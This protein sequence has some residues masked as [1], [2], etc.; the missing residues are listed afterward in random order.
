MQV[1]SSPS[2]LFKAGRYSELAMLGDSGHQ[3]DHQAE[4]WAD[5]WEMHAARAMIGMPE[6][7][8][9]PLGRFDDA[10]ARFFQAA[11][12]WIAGDAQ[13]ARALC[14]RLDS[15]AAA[16]LA[17]LLARD[18]LDILC[19]LPAN[20]HGPHVHLAGA[21]ADP[22]FRIANISHH[23]DDL[24]LRP[25][26]SIWNYADRE[27]PP[28]L[29]LCEMVEWH[30]IPTDFQELPCPLIGV[31]S[32]FDLHIQGIQP[33]LNAFDLVVVNDHTEYAGLRGCITP[34]MAVFPLLFGCPA[35]LP[36]PA[37]GPRDIDLFM[38]GTLFATYHPDKAALLHAAL[39][40]PDL[41]VVLVNGHMP[42]AAY[43]D[44]LARSKLTASYY[45]RPG[46]MVTRGIEAACMGCVL[47]L[48]E[49]SVLDL[50]A[51]AR[52]G[53]VAYDS[54]PAGLVRAIA[55]ARP[56]LPDLQRQAAAAAGHFR[57]VFAGPAVAS[58]F[59]R[60]MAVLGLLHP[61]AGRPAAAHLVQKRNMFW[62][63]WQPG[64]GDLVFAAALKDANLARWAA[65]SSEVLSGEMSAVQRANEESREIL[66]EAA[67]GA[68]TRKTPE[69]P[70]GLVAPALERLGDAVAEAP[71][72]LV[73]AFNHIRCCLH[74]GT[75]EQ[76]AKAVGQAR[77]MAARP[78]DF[79]QVGPL[80][81]VYPYDFCSDHFNYRAYLDLLVAG[82]QPD[83][84]SWREDS[85]REAVRLLLAGL[86]H[87]LAL[88]LD[89]AENAARARELDPDF[90]PYLLDLAV[91][92][93]T[94]GAR[95]APL[96]PALAGLV[97]NSAFAPQAMALLRLAAE[98]VP[99]LCDLP[100]C[101]LPEL[102]E[103]MG[104]YERALV[105][106]DSHP[107]K[108]QSAYF[109]HQSLGPAFGAKGRFG[110][111]V[112]GSAEGSVE[113]PDD[114]GAAELSIIGCEAAWFRRVAGMAAAPLRMI[115]V[116]PSQAGVAAELAPAL[117]VK[118]HQTT[119]LLHPGRAMNAGLRLARSRWVAL[120]AASD[121]HASD[122]REGGMASVEA[123][124]EMLAALSAAAEPRVAGTLLDTDGRL[125]ALVC[126]RIDALLC[127]GLEAHQGRF[128][129]PPDLEQLTSRLCESGVRLLGAC[130]APP[131]PPARPAVRLWPDLFAVTRRRRPHLEDA[132]LASLG[133][134]LLCGSAEGDDMLRMPDGLD[135][136]YQLERNL[137]SRRIDGGLRI[138]R[139]RDPDPV[140]DRVLVGP[141]IRCLPGTYRLRPQ[142]HNEGAAPVCC[143]TV[144]LL[145]EADAPVQQ[146]EW[147][148]GGGGAEIVFEIAKPGRF[149]MALIHIGTAVWDITGLRL[150]RDPTAVGN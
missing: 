141:A 43:F 95:L 60:T 32:D 22:L 147:L 1:S 18:R 96:L 75:P 98:A 79:W 121:G 9:E 101:D 21:A 143:L 63:G 99:G 120:L 106:N 82:M 10:Q 148:L 66:L 35:D 59:L 25:G 68:I 20:R 132:G 61:P 80:D 126:R 112:E 27:A 3:A 107:F 58:R 118:T 113:G 73:P 83:G 94:D 128:G 77:L 102:E 62:K 123:L 144:D 19:Q 2:A 11:A 111:V 13:A 50:Y 67:A 81:D 78:E 33:W 4:H 64:G 53:M 150:W 139:V 133:L 134:D 48:Q 76:Q 12:C 109:L 72:A 135:L 37:D 88:V 57:S 140:L 114:A 116:V 129:L 127:G 47:L 65:L 16:R 74:F 103:H 42:E 70:A 71:D 69:W 28:D 93:G 105:E 49:G 91:R 131:S 40:L 34:S 92:C 130:P 23:P 51:P 104:R 136:L 26:A 119:P 30:Q 45:R 56:R 84:L 24:P 115:H 39:D 55:G 90:P 6:L 149:R 38:S 7:A 52:H 85:G 110:P 124:R 138:E 97:R 108:L 15:P 17:A 146:F 29:F 14:R 36:H 44:F 137:N 86:H 5:S 145:E 31:T 41:K 125:A 8:V 122:G 89:S 54:T 142:I 117:L 87:Y 100:G 46:G